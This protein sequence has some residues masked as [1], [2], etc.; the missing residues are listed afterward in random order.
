MLI[1]LPFNG[2]E[3]K[4]SL[5]F[6]LHRLQSTTENPLTLTN[7]IWNLENY[8]LSLSLSI[9][10]LHRLCVFAFSRAPSTATQHRKHCKNETQ[11]LGLRVMALIFGRIETTLKWWWWWW[12]EFYFTCFFFLSLFCFPWRNQCEAKNRELS[13][14]LPAETIMRV[15]QNDFCDR[16]RDSTDRHIVVKKFRIRNVYICPSASEHICNHSCGIRSGFHYLY[17]KKIVIS[18]ANGKRNK[19]AIHRNTKEQH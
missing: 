7:L 12:W 15:M 3:E 18:F 4:N 16:V 6:V 17:V 2:R 5:F 9:I 1:L 11:S 8:S 14:L 19:N 13:L 10:H